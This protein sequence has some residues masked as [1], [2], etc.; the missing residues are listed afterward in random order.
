MRYKTISIDN[1]ADLSYSGVYLCIKTDEK[2]TREYLGNVST[3]VINSLEVRLTTFLINALNKEGIRLVFT[4]NKKF[5]SS[6]IMPLHATGDTYHK[7]K[8]QLSWKTN[9]KDALWSD[10]VKNKIKMQGEF[11]NSVGRDFETQ[12]FL[13]M[14]I[15]GDIRNAEGYAARSYFLRLFGN[16]YSRRKDHIINAGLNYGYAI[17]LSLISRIIVSYG[18]LTELGIHHK[19]KRNNFN[20]ASDVMEPFR[21]IVDKIVYENQDKEELDKEYKQKL[22]LVLDYPVLY[23]NKEYRLNEAAEQYFLNI[24]RILNKDA[25][26][27]TEVK[28]V[29][30]R[31]VYNCYV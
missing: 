31:W 16:G 15:H 1:N 28:Y 29:H 18:F 12:R 8:E 6:I 7:V 5:P 19:S 20:F 9:D 23:G 22:I 2:F 21:P 24:V 17:L 27:L 30:K 10:I 3:I 4:D 13:E 11:L 25:D 26:T 14:V